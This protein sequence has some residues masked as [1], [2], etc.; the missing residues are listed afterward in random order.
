MFMPE[1]KPSRIFQRMVGKDAVVQVEGH[2][3]T[4]ETLKDH[5]WKIIGLQWFGNQLL[6]ILPGK[7]EPVTLEQVKA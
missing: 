3:Y 2:A 1:E 5:Q 6:G 4:H 7:E